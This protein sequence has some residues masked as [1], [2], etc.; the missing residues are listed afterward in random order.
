MQ[1]YIYKVNI[2]GSPYFQLINIADQPMWWQ[3]IHLPSSL[4][5]KC[6]DPS[7]IVRS[8]PTFL[9]Q[10]N[11]ILFCDFQI[12]YI[13]IAVSEI[14]AAI[15]GLEYA[16]TKAPK[17][18]RSLVMACFLFMTA[19]SSAIGE[20]FVC[21]FCLFVSFYLCYWYEHLLHLISSIRGPTTCV[22]LRR[23]GSSCIDNGFPVL[24][25]RTWSRCEGRRVE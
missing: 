5:S 4:S 3:S 23:H 16:F 2:L 25:V 11:L 8:C 22:E 20:I 12:R 19:L 18:M 21:K 17:N 14:L 10:I 24:V 6:L 15:T 7:W 9:L 13:L 1:H